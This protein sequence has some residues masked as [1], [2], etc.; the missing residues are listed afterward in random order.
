VLLRDGQ[1]AWSGRRRE[2]S[3]L[4]S[5]NEAIDGVRWSCNS[6][7]G[8]GGRPAVQRRPAGLG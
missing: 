5:M 8:G 4:R 2:V 1:D 7:G 6:G 3:D